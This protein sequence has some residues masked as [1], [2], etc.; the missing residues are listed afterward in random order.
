LRQ[1]ILRESTNGSGKRRVSNFIHQS[2]HVQC[3]RSSN[4]HGIRIFILSHH[5][6]HIYLQYGGVCMCSCRFV[7][8][9]Q[10]KRWRA[11]RK[12]VSGSKHRDTSAGDRSIAPGNFLRSHMH[13]PAIL[14]IFAGKWFV[15]PSIMR[16]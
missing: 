6:I 9:E 2:T 16:S 5:N 13:D 12:L 4:N 7:N 11:K 1:C 10:W 3:T 8:Q 14:C 15:M